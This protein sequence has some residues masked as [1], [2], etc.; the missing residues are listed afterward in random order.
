MWLWLYIDSSRVCFSWL[1]RAWIAV[2]NHQPLRKIAWDHHPIS[3]DGNQIASQYELQDFRRNA[4]RR[5]RDANFPAKLHCIVWMYSR[6]AAV[7]SE[8]VVKSGQRWPKAQIYGWET[9][10]LSGNHWKSHCF[11]KMNVWEFILKLEFL[12]S[13]HLRQV[14]MLTVLKRISP[15]QKYW[16]LNWM[17]KRKNPQNAESCV[18]VWLV[19]FSIY[20]ESQTL[21][22]KYH[23]FQL[24]TQTILGL[25]G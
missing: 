16:L 3:W 2:E 9:L 10:R 17:R 20:P 12:K 13:Q 21:A 25:P 8:A 23:Q 22:T 18:S 4:P 15:A 11:I 14:Y 19:Q 1:I 5:K 24:L 6:T 7:R